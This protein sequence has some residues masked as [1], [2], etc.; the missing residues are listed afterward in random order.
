MRVWAGYYALF[1]LLP[2]RIFA[3]IGTW[4]SANKYIIEKQKKKQGTGWGTAAQLYIVFS[5][6]RLSY[7]NDNTNL[8][9]FFYLRVLLF[10]F[11]VNSSAVYVGLKPK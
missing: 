7:K 11:F 3:I 4:R 1:I 8:I 10:Y 9:K 2:F 6:I 5:I